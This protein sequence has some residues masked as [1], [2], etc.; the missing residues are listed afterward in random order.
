M[1][2]D[3]FLGQL[4]LIAIAVISFA[5]G[6]GWLS[7]ADSSLAGALLPPVGLL[8][9]PWI[10]S[11]YSNVNK[12]LVPH[13]S[14]AVESAN[15]VGATAKGAS[16]S[17]QGL[18]KVVGTF[19]IAVTLFAMAATPSFAADNLPVKSPLAALQSNCNAGDCSGGYVLFGADM[20]AA[21]ASTLTGG[22]NQGNGLDVGGGYQ[23]WQGQILAGIEGTA[24]YRFG[25]GGATGSF[26]STQFVK[27]GYNFF[28][29]NAAAA[30]SPSQSPLGGLVPANLL[31]N[32]TPAVLM[33]G[34]YGH[35]IEKGCVGLEVDTVI[36]K[37][38]SSAFQ[39]YNAPSFKGQPDENVF[40]I[41]VQK[42]LN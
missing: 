17:V 35:G 3:F 21:L 24:G 6:K 26:T 22:S 12:K 5:T 37:G 4:R 32:S 33:G 38:W 10:W 9:G 29:S 15:V 39:W 30:P 41:L 20:N 23:Y 19:L 7:A 18:A 11:I 36:A 27:L 14:V 2:Q 34:C 1:T 31:Q 16:V 40:R 8:L 28:P 42:H 25:T 13:D